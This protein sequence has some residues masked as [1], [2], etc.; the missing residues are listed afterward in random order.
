MLLQYNHVRKI[1]QQ[2]K[3]R[4]ETVMPVSKIRTI[5]KKGIFLGGLVM[6]WPLGYLLSRLTALRPSLIE[7]YYSRGYANILTGFLSR[8][9]GIFPFSLA[10]VILGFFVMAACFFLVLLSARIIEAVKDGLG[11]KIKPYKIKQGKK[12]KKKG[13][14]GLLLN[15][16]IF[17]GLVYFGF[18]LIW[19]LNY[20]RL[21]FADIA[22]LKV[23]NASE[24]DLETLC[25]QLID[26]AN[27]LRVGLAEDE[28]GVMCVPGGFT[29]VRRTA[30]SAYVR[31]ALLYPELGGRFGQPKPVYFSKLMSYSGI[32]GVYFPFTGEANVNIDIPDSMLPATT[33]H[34]MAH[35]RGF[36][37]EDEANYIAWVACSSS[38]DRYFQYSG[39][40]LALIH[41]MN[42]LYEHAPQQAN[43]LSQKYGEGLRRDLQAIS[44]YWESYEG[45]VEEFS[46]DV[47]D[48][49]LKSNGQEEGVESYGRMVDLLLAEQKENSNKK[50]LP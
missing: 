9:T 25:E 50:F 2:E 8:A 29:E 6:L 30:P 48:A 46:S 24:K 28:Q 4:R 31:A 43:N 39:T 12:K 36:A 19:G 11:L 27:R 32:S 47:N 7:V 18:V 14:F 38:T 17:L 1:N 22:G 13:F 41:S 35:Q 42:A 34:E 16:L 45:R 20:N 23:G 44:R 26:K 37:R 49:Y 10:E 21:P 5:R 15:A 33:C 40:L 3:G